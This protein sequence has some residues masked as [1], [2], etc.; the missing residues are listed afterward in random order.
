MSE[1]RMLAIAFTSMIAM[2]A[3][4]AAIL[5]AMSANEATLLCVTTLVALLSY[6][7]VCLYC[8][9]LVKRRAIELTQAAEGDP[10]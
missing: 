5:I 4:T 10:N 1:F 7:S 9:P 6:L 2:A 3:L 8:L